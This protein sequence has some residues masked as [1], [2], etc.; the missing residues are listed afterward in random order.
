MNIISPI[1][2]NENIELLY[3]IPTQDIIFSYKKIFNIDVGCY[4]KNLEEISVFK[5][6]DTGYIFFTPLGLSGDALFYERLGQFNWYYMD[7]KW[8]YSQAAKEVENNFKVLEIGCGN[9]SFLRSLSKKGIFCIGTEIGEKKIKENKFFIFKKTLENLFF[10]YNDYFDVVCS[11]QVMEHISNINEELLNSIK[12]LKKGGKLIISVPNNDSFLGRDKKNPLNM[13]P[14]HMG[15]WSENFLNNIQVIY[16]LK[17]EKII[18]E[19][20]QRYHYRYFYYIKFGNKI[21]NIFGLLGSLF[22]FLFFPFFSFLLFFL[23]NKIKGHTVFAVY[24]KIK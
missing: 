9:G 15:L 17:M 20:L 24:R 13:P 1:T 14:H 5:C 19:P 10:E 3:K 11:F 7:W 2:K 4:F 18:F 22:N 12:L 6:V 21:K 8:E 23:R 16:N